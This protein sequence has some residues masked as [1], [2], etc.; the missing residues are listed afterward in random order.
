MLASSGETTPPTQWIAR[1]MVTL[2]AS[3]GVMPAGAACAGGDA[4]PDGDLLRTDEDVLDQQPQYS[5]ALGDGSSGSAG[6]QLGEEA[7][8][9]AGEL[10]VGVPVGGLGVEPVNLAAEVGFTCAQVRHPGAQLVDGDELLGV[11]LDHGGDRAT[12]EGDVAQSTCGRRP[13]SI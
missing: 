7:L 9:V 12:R 2:R 3:V 13:S 10:E 8:Q 5:L 11:G 6:V 4:V 1:A